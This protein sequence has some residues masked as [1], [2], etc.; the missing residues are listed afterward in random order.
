MDP[1]CTIPRRCTPFSAFV[2]Q[3]MAQEANNQ[4]IRAVAGV[5]MDLS[6]LGPVVWEHDA[7]AHVLWEFERSPDGATG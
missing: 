4:R 6:L 3:V 2:V 5:V 1:G 7:D